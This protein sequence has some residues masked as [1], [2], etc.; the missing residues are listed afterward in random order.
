MEKLS[1]RGSFVVIENPIKTMMLESPWVVFAAAKEI[2][3]EVHLGAK[4]EWLREHGIDCLDDETALWR[5]AIFAKIRLGAA[6][7]HA[8]S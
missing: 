2:H 6:A 3:K 8:L 5:Y 1:S 4:H 7:L